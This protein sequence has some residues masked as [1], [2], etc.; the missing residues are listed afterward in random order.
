M[1]IPASANT[2]Q[3]TEFAV[4]SADGVPGGIAVT[5]DGAVWSTSGTAHAFDI[6]KCTG[7]AYSGG[8]G[9]GN[10]VVG[11]DGALWYSRPG[12]QAIGRITTSGS[13][14]EFPTALGYPGW[15][16][17]GPDGALWFTLIQGV[18]GMTTS[19]EALLIYS[20]LTYPSSITTG[21]D[22]NLWVTGAYQD[23]VG[24]LTPAG[25]ATLFRIATGC[26]SYDIAR[27]DKWLWVACGS[28]TSSK[29]SPRR[30][31]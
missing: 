22:G 24:R 21:P 19:G 30:V 16:T 27:G 12:N 20:R 5:S 29:G 28:L 15:V 23:E 7:C 31:G 14:H 11:P 17:P 18:A 9:L 3:I 26:A 6:P 4:P 10:I 13:V 25:R 1:V 2:P 8:N